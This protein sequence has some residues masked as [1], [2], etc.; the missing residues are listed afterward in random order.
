MD[1][2]WPSAGPSGHLPGLS[3]VPPLLPSLLVLGPRHAL[4]Q[5]AT[6]PRASS[7]SPT[8]PKGEADSLPL[9][10]HSA[11]GGEDW[12]LQGSAAECW[13]GCGVGDGTQV[14]NTCVPWV[15]T[16]RGPQGPPP[17][18]RCSEQSHAAERRAVA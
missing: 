16:G 17:V 3:S 2:P 18:V 6:P 5:W 14:S 13:L 11:A 1:R 10:P 9:P 8:L 15:S 12:G 4:C 7:L